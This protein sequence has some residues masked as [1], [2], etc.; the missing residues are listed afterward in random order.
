MFVIRFVPRR[1][2]DM[3][4]DMFTS[5]IRSSNA[6]HAC[7]FWYLLIH[8]MHGQVGGEKVKRCWYRIM[9]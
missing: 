1:S 9:I 6:L 5:A 3:D 4:M 8:W 7:S 2:R